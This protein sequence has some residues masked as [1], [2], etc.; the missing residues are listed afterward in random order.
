MKVEGRGEFFCCAANAISW[1]VKLLSIQL[2]MVRL[3]HMRLIFENFVFAPTK[4]CQELSSWQSNGQL[5]K[6]MAEKS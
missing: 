6:I 1:I 3:S 5:G 2:Y 4:L